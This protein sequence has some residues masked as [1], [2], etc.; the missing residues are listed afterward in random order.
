MLQKITRISILCLILLT[1][2]ACQ[3]A[4]YSG[5]IANGLVLDADADGFT[6]ATAGQPLLFPQDFGAH[7]DFQTEWWYY[8]GNLKTAE[9]R[10]FGYQFT[11]F[12]R[13]LVPPTADLGE[14]EWRTGQVYFAHA[15][16]ADV[17]ENRFLFGDRFARGGAG[18]AGAK[19]QPYEIWIED[20]E[21]T[22]IEPGV[23]KMRAE[24]SGVGFEFILTETQPPVLH[25]DNG[26]SPKAADDRFASFYY[27]LVDLKTE[28]E[29]WIGDERFSVTGVSWK[30]HEYSSDALPEGVI[31]WNWFSAQFDN[32]ES[33]MFAETR[34]RGDEI[35]YEL[36][37]WIDENSNVTKI[38]PGQI[39]LEVLETWTS[40]STE[41]TYPAKWT[42]IDPTRN[43][44]LTIE[45]L[46]DDAELR[47]GAATYW[48][49]PA[50]YS[51][52][53]DG[54]PISGYGYIEMTGYAD[55]INF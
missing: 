25:G 49:G 42:L 52:T 14:N 43:L 9:G 24:E 37:S 36:G 35:G 45:T 40:P 12:R 51:G 4:T 28:G 53:L 46:V 54:E 1:L 16:I 15:A 27:T 3:Q 11:I 33:L 8:T 5:S 50:F 2:S 10:D 38:E 19:G 44:E 47:V 22:E 13:A 32:G 6:R 55:E 34:R 17:E 31:G 30:D 21:V 39:E 18:L 20:W 7:D 23:Y 41:A 29:L 26:F 48:E